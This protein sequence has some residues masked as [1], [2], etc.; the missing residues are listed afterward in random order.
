MANPILQFGT[1]RFLQ[2]HVDLFVDEAL[3]AGQALGPITVVQTTANP[4][5]ARRVAAFNAPG[6][7]PVRIRG[8]AGGA[9]IDAE[10]R[11]TAIH[12]A[13][14][15]DSDWP[16]LRA[17]VSG[18]DVQ[19]IVS[20]TGDRGYDLSA[21][22]TAALLDGAGV[23]RSFPAKLLVLL[24][25][26]HQRGGAPLTLYPCELVANNGS[27]LRDVV[28]GLARAWRV[29]DACV[30]WLGT[31]CTWVNSLVDRI[32]SEAIEP[33]GAVAEPY[34]IWVIEAQP[35]M[36][37]PC[38][39]PQVVVTDR[40]E[41]YER[42]KLFLLN[43]GHTWLA[44]EWLRQGRPRNETVRAAMADAALRAG[45]EALWADEVLPVFAAL[46]DGDAARAYVD[47]VRDRFLNPFLDHRLA[48]IAQNHEEK[49]RRRLAPVVALAAELGLDLP[50][51]RLRAALDLPPIEGRNA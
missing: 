2:A 5:S 38:T 43:L 21:D 11:V 8:R 26:R 33:A 16:A 30:D 48:D 25:A 50:Q 22:D 34:A 37:L 44:G 12:G 32:V 7:Y 20:N 4:Q 27:V 1:S 39:H 45:L 41:P 29:D 13:L 49:T 51:P 14:Q 23:P 3:A 17:L 10:R 46:G 15:A 31:S 18:P 40:L 28:L 6:G 9:T 42:R 36:V 19:V 47:E 24:H 35:G